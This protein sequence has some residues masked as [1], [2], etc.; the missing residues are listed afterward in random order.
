MQAVGF[1]GQGWMLGGK[2]GGPFPKPLNAKC[3][4]QSSPEGMS[5]SEIFKYERASRSFGGDKNLP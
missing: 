1:N 4:G 2:R 3:S 5:C